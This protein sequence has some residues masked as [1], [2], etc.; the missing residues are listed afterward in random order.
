MMARTTGR[1][2]RIVCGDEE[3]RAFGPIALP[4]DKPPLDIEQELRSRVYEAEQALLHWI[5]PAKWCG[6]LNAVAPAI[7]RVPVH[8]PWALHW[9]SRHDGALKTRAVYVA[10]GPDIDGEKEL[11]GLWVG[12]NEGAKFWLSVFT[13]LPNRVAR[14][15]ASD[16]AALTPRL[17]IQRFGAD[18]SGS[19]L[20][21]PRC[22]G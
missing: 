22:A 16:V 9:K 17:C 8:V 4:P 2:E 11:L 1:Y 19:T 18:P 15:P 14:Y 13:E 12:E 3:V 6:R 10:L 5:S 21:Q 7:E 20:D